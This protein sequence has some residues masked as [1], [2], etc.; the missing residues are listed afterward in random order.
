MNEQKRIIIVLGPTSSGKSDIAIKLA[1]KFDGEIISADSR[2]IYRGLD[3]GTGKVPRDKKSLAL[4]NSESSARRRKKPSFDLQ[5]VYFSHGISHYMI[6]IISPHTDYNVAKFKKQT[7]KIIADILQR[8]RLPIICGGTGFWIR[9]IVDNVTFPEVKPDWK[10]RKKLEKYPAEKLFVM[11]KKFDPDRAK[12]IDPKNKVR[13][14][15]AIEICKTLKRVPKIPD[16]EYE[17]PDTKHEFLQIGIKLSKERLHQ[18]IKKRLKARFKQGMVAEVKKLHADGLSWK[19]IQSFGLGYYWIP[20]YLQ[21]KLNKDELF[22][23][24]LQA[25]K[26]YAKRQMT[27]FKRDKKIK[28]VADLGETKR[29]IK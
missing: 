14:I 1:K 10:L 4:R 5:K 3:I 24:V 20:L 13:L 9:T 2:Q 7:E 19:K 17:I 22:E 28:W 16:T 21:G 11:L 15:R 8:G 18:N 25:E 23:K 6:D 12:T 29:I 27:W 26:D